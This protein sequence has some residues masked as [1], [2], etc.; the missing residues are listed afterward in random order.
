MWALGAVLA[1]ALVA[2]VVLVPRFTAREAS[3]PQSGIVGALDEVSVSGRVGATPVVA[4]AAPV[5]VGGVKA[6]ELATG[7]GR[8]ITEGSPVLL[9]L[10]SFDGDTGDSLST[11]G[12]PR[13]I[14]GV[15][16]AD[17]LGA[18]IASLVIG[19]TEGS[20]I[21]AIHPVARTDGSTRARA[22][23][24]VVDVL[25]TIAY[26]DENTFGQAGALQVTM[27]P[28]GPVI[29][30]DSA[31]PGGLT[32]QTLIEGSGQQVGSDDRV[33]AQFSVVGWTDGV[34]RSSTW[35]TGMP[36]LIDLSSAM[37]GLREAIVDRRVGSRLAISIPP[38]LAT[39]DDTLCVVIDVLGAEPADSSS[40]TSGA[41]TASSGSASGADSAASGERAAQ[42]GSG[43]S[44]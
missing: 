12:R 41:G 37:K 4:L 38:D 15:A 28:E 14:V 22:E 36:E 3:G 34:V 29:K 42:S 8:S 32:V 7:S 6:K 40:G 43:A 5:E 39:G 30:H 26:G 11:T 21:L 31:V 25:G 13:L 24:T 17:T 44:Q 19:R 23:I 20:R 10:T 9:S 35:E 27:T 33:V 2:L 18:D 16:N 1:L